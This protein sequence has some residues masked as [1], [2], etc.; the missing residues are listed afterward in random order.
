MAPDPVRASGMSE[1]HRGPHDGPKKH[2]ARRFG[3][4]LAWW[5]MRLTPDSSLP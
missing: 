1:I 4:A 5:I 3:N 2:S